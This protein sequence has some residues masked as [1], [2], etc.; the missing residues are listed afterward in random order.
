MK[1]N[2]KKGETITNENGAVWN[3]KVGILA[4]TMLYRRFYEERFSNWK[5]KIILN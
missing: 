1:Q 4:P 3:I 2:S 5:L